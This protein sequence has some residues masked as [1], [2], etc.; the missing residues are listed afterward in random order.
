MKYIGKLLLECVVIGVAA[1]ILLL[2]IWHFFSDKIIK[3]LG[4]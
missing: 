1:G 2:V 3:F 4:S